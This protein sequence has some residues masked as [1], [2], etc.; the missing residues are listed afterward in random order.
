MVADNGAA[1]MP[2]FS[3]EHYGLLTRISTRPATGE[4]LYGELQHDAQIH[5]LPIHYDHLAWVAGLLSDWPAESDAWLSYF[6]RIKHGPAYQ[7]EVTANT[8]A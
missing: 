3:N 6:Q 2:N 5:A 7:I 1:G 8:K 4:V